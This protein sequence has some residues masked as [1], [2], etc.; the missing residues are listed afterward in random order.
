MKWNENGQLW[1]FTRGRQAGKRG[2]SRVATLAILL[3]CLA[4]LKY[5]LA[6][7]KYPVFNSYSVFYKHLSRPFV[8]F[9]LLQVIIHFF[10]YLARQF[11]FFRVYL[12]ILTVRSWYLCLKRGLS[13]H[14]HICNTGPTVEIIIH[15]LPAIQIWTAQKL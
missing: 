13:C 12:A 11:S 10:L 15:P 7:I 4:N 3:L 2:L 8:L 9:T 6:I 5:P 1:Q 14:I